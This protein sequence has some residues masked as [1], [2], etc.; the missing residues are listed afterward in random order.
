MI[1]MMKIT[2][3]EITTQKRRRKEKLQQHQPQKQLQV[4]LYPCRV[5]CSL[6]WTCHAKQ[7]W[8]RP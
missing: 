3:I 7:S 4:I 6:V 1:T 2:E 8:S 5:C